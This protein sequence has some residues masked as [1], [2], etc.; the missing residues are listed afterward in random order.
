MYVGACPE[1]PTW[2]KVWHY[3]GP[4]KE[5]L[6]LLLFFQNSKPTGLHGSHGVGYVLLLLSLLVAATGCCW[7]PC[8]HH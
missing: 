8:C 3:V 2:P 5:F 6:H 1:Q 7:L 4:K